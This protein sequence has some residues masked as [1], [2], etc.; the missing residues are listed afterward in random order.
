MVQ[1][2]RK[3]E[4]VTKGHKVVQLV[5]RSFSIL[6]EISKR[7]FMMYNSVG[8]AT[9]QAHLVS[10]S[11]T[12]Q[13]HGW[14]GHVM[15]KVSRKTTTTSFIIYNFLVARAITLKVKNRQKISSV[16]GVHPLLWILDEHV[17]VTRVDPLMH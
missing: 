4:L 9:G 11:V 12:R 13:L 7:N 15:K 3:Q 8:R 17:G 16:S 1:A 5:E 14:T 6:G 2:S 10:C